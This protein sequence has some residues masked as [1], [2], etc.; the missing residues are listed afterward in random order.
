MKKFILGIT[1]LFLI[2][3][4][5]GCKKSNT[6]TELSTNKEA[7]ETSFYKDKVT[8]YETKFDM[9]TSYVEDSSVNYDENQ[10]KH[11]EVYLAKES[12]NILV[13]VDAS[14][15]TNKNGNVSRIYAQYTTL[16]NSISDYSSIINILNS[17]SSISNFDSAKKEVS[18]PDGYFD[19]Q[20]DQRVLAIEYSV[21]FVKYVEYQSDAAFPTLYTC[22]FVPTNA[23]LTTLVDNKFA[24]SSINSKY[25]TYYKFSDASAISD[26]EE[27]SINK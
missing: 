20:A 18:I 11:Y 24:D 6:S 3:S 25:D 21:V 5:V 12:F 7:F 23:T 1:S 14:T 9:T 4:L 15:V 2:I 10:T 22:V 27:I 16:A 13:S 19:T 17:I 26:Y 8:D